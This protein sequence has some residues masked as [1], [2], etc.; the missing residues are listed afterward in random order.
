MR[1]YIMYKQPRFPGWLNIGL[2][3]SLT[4]THTR[5]L[6]TKT[7]AFSSSSLLCNRK[8]QSFSS[9]GRIP[10]AWP[11]SSAGFSPSVLEKSHWM[12]KKKRTDSASHYRLYQLLLVIYF[13]QMI[14]IAQQ[15]TTV[16]MLCFF[17]GW[18]E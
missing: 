3:S 10:T 11:Q 9:E 16:E 14:T 6:S 8:V 4:S 1:S 7:E 18:L 13:T 17:A 15:H 2:F 12:E 5:V